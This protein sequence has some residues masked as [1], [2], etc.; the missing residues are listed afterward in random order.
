[1]AKYRVATGKIHLRQNGR[2]VVYRP[3]D[4]LEADPYEVKVYRDQLD[5]IDGEEVLEEQEVLEQPATLTIQ[6]RGGGKYNVLDQ[7][8]NPVND[9]LL[10]RAE[11]EDLVQGRLKEEVSDDEEIVDIEDDETVTGNDKDEEE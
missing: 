3:G 4:V 5:P 9:R 2:R 7:D 11:A 6:H 8:G 10:T 1:M